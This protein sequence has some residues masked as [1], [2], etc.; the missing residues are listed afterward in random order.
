MCIS[1]CQYSLFDDDLNVCIYSRFNAASLFNVH[2]TSSASYRKLLYP[3]YFLFY[4]N[5]FP[6]FAFTLWGRTGDLRE[7]IANEKCSKLVR[8]VPSLVG[9][10]FIKSFDLFTTDVEMHELVKGQWF[11]VLY[12]FLNCWRIKSDFHSFCKSKNYGTSF[13]N[14]T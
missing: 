12:R 6:R 10:I 9:I 8:I 13:N 1:N 3:T 5:I 11:L 2:V 14:F 7:S 4:N